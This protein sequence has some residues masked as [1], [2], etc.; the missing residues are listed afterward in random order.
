[1]NHAKSPHPHLQLEHD[2]TSQI[3]SKSSQPPIDMASKPLL[4]RDTAA[5]YSKYYR[6]AL[7]TAPACAVSVLAGVGNFLL[8]TQPL[9]DSIV[10]P[11]EYQDSDAVVGPSHSHNFSS[12]QIADI[13]LPPLLVQDTPCK[14]KASVDSSQVST[15]CSEEMTPLSFCDRHGSSIAFHYTVENLLLFH[16]SS[17]KIQDR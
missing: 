17:S 2:H 12:D 4:D 16:L 6:Q 5:Y 15:A 1:M 11:G 14:R 8:S 7:A 3:P 13:S 10:T 9:I